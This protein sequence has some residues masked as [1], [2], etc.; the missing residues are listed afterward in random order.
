MDCELRAGIRAKENKN[1]LAGQSTGTMAK[2][3]PTDPTSA[4]NPGAEVRLPANTLIGLSLLENL[5]V[6]YQHAYFPDIK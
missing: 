1:K 3:N 2:H 4:F 6:I 5:D